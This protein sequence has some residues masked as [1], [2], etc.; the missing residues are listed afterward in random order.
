MTQ[1]APDFAQGHFNLGIALKTS[2]RFTDAIAAYQKAII[3]DPNY[4][5]AL[6]NLGIVL[7]KVGYFQEAIIAF[8]KAIR[9]HE[10]QHN[11]ETAEILR[12][13]LQ[14]L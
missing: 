7:M 4:A 13:V 8:K 14:T 9:L 2:G 12:S 6:Q 1:I 11:Y 3:L 10:Q 5:D